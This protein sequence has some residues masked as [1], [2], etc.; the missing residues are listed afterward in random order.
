[1]QQPTIE[2]LA[3]NLLTMGTTNERPRR[4]KDYWNTVRRTACS[5]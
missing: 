3:V 2:V 1:L 5:P 4:I